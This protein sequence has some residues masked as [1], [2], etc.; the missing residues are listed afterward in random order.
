M[1]RRE[2][3]NRAETSPRRPPR[4][5]LPDGEQLDQ[6]RRRAN[7]R[8]RRRDEGRPGQVR[9][10]K[11]ARAGVEQIA[12]LTGREVQGVVSVKPADSGWVVGVEVLE[13]HRVPSTADL[14]ALYEIEIDHD[15]EPMAYARKRRYTR[16]TTDPAESAV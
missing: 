16:G 13:D 10:M 12:M 8:P 1:D 15:G 6:Q 7:D 4:D 3:Q 5:E 11:A 14:L 9:A 2:G